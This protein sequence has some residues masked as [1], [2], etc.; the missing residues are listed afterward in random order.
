MGHHLG[1]ICSPINMAHSKKVLFLLALVTHEFVGGQ[2]Y[3]RMSRAPQSLMKREVKYDLWKWSLGKRGPVSLMKRDEFGLDENTF[4]TF[5][6]AGPDPY[7][8]YKD[9]FGKRYSHPGTWKRGP[10]HM[11]RGKDFE[12]ENSKNDAP[13]IYLDIPLDLPMM[14][15]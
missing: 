11:W 13:F 9:M 1:V 8:N 5:Y 12:S 3:V 4:G 14:G 7:N 15:F 10:E 2:S 6:E